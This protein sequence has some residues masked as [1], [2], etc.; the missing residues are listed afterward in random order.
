M[1]ALA[2]A[3]GAAL[4]L[5]GSPAGAQGDAV[6][7]VTAKEI[8]VGAVIGKTNPTGV[9]YEQVVT[10]AQA[11]FDALNKKGGVFGRKLKITKVL[12]DQTRSSK[13]II[14][15]RSLVE[16]SKVF[17]ALVAT[18]NFSGAQ[19]FADAGTPTFGYNIQPEWSK[20]PN[21]FGTYGSFLC[22]DCPSISP[23]YV[24]QQVGASRVAL[25]A[26]GG[27]AAGPTCIAA[28]KQ[29][30]DKY[31]P[32]VVVVDTSLSYG[33]SAN[34]ISGA[35]QAI[36]D[37][38]VDFVAACMDIQGE[39]NLKK[40]LEA[41]GVTGVKFYAPQGYDLETIEQLGDDLDDF[42][43]PVRF[44]PFELAKT[45]AGMTTFVKAMKARGL[46]PTEN[47][48][49]G[50]VGASLLAEGIQAAGKDFTQAS[51]VD[52][53]NQITAWTADG[54]IAPVNWQHAHGPPQAGDQDCWA[55]VAAE[56]GKFVPK[57]G[58]TNK[59]FVCNPSSPFPPTLDNPTFLGG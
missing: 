44:I 9:D 14:A 3:F 39:L 57:Y 29:A 4:L 23:V 20:G 36:K 50:W 53:I 32:R 26:Y 17:A 8:Q 10:G 51:V 30:F 56:N 6:P 5:A 59:P 49:V 58:E 47:L 46:V 28:Q 45:S 15:A 12:D 31:G 40:A 7:G 41:A 38:D 42:T 43:F 27:G 18:Q 16:E 19:V 55:Y 1:R 22:S 2:L 48:L 24:A 25:L 52:A 34:D 33:F 13:S 35:V 11:R 54:M 21:L 37:N